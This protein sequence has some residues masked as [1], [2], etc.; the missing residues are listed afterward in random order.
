MKHEET[1]IVRQTLIQKSQEQS[2]VTNAAA[3]G[4]K[5]IATRIRSMSEA[6]MVKVVDG[7]ERQDYMLDQT[8][9]RQIDGFQ[10]VRNWPVVDNTSNT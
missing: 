10:P 2:P 4:G 8:A 3:A 6:G 1:D 7:G 9:R 5:I